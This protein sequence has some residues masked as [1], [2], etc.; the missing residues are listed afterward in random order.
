MKNRLLKRLELEGA[1][2]AII[3]LALLLT[4][5]AWIIVAYFYPSLPAIVA[6]HYGINGTSDSYNYKSGLL[7]L[8]AIFTAIT[9]LLILVIRYRYALF[10]KYPYFLNLP[11]F[12]YHLSMQNDKTKQA[13]ILNKVFTVYTF[14][15]LMISTLNLIFTFA[16]FSRASTILYFVYAALI[17][18]A[19]MLLA[20]FS[21]Y[22]RIYK[23]FSR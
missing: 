7:Y 2:K 1:S 14:P 3:A 5:F 19:I 12:I 9:A 6:A 18:I 4:I 17:L 10:E 13:V 21:L 8:P 11:S 20:I 15:L 22:R 23:E 16:T